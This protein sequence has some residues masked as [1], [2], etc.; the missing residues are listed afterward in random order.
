MQHRIGSS[1]MVVRTHHTVASICI[2]APASCHI[3]A[4]MQHSTPYLFSL[5][6][7][8]YN[9]MHTLGLPLTAANALLPVP[10]R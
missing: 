4:G 2:V 7:G 8:T 6:F 9:N 1:V 3:T 10:H 5:A